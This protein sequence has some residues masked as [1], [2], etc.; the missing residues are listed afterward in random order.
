MMLQTHFPNTDTCHIYTGENNIKKERNSFSFIIMYTTLY[1]NLNIMI[2]YILLRQTALKIK[3]ELLHFRDGDMYA[4]L[5]DCHNALRLD[6]N[7]LKAHFR[8]AKCLNELCWP[9]EAYECL[10]HFKTKFPDY[11]T[12]RAC[13]QLDKDIR[14]AI[15][16]KT[17]NGKIFFVT[18]HQGPYSQTILNIIFN[19]ILNL[20]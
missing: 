15:F 9:K 19:V 3:H 16:A 6:L 18:L 11:A 10:N 12:S 8:L 4:A 7:H 2:I 13:E 5:R 17:E 20:K 1:L 14:A